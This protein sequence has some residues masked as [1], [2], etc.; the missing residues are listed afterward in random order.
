MFLAGSDT[1]K[2]QS[3][4][5]HVTTRPC[6]RCV[7]LTVLLL[8]TLAVAFGETKSVQPHW[9]VVQ[10]FALSV[11]YALRAFIGPYSVLPLNGTLS[12]YSTRLTQVLFRAYTKA[13]VKAKEDSVLRGDKWGDRLSRPVLEQSQDP[14]MAA[15]IRATRLPSER[16]GL[17]RKL[18]TQNHKSLLSVAKRSTTEKNCPR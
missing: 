4:I 8:S 10:L 12:A 15:R 1:R 14:Q 17:Q 18:Q 13:Q 5:V 7:R 6:V 3:V 2:N 11:A 9:I 16:E